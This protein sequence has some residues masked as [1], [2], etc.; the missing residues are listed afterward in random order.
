MSERKRLDYRRLSKARRPNCVEARPP[1]KPPRCPE[2]G[3]RTVV[4]APNDAW[5][6]F[7]PACRRVVS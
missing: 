4:K 1:G 2:G 3:G 5:V 6:A 7:W